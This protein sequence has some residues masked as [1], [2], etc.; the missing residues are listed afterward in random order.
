MNPLLLRYVLPAV[1]GLLLLLGIYLWGRSDGSNS[2]QA[3]WDRE[4]L[5]NARAVQQATEKARQTEAQSNAAIESNRRRS[6]AQIADI[7]RRRDAALQRLRD[8]ATPGGF[9]LPADAPAQSSER[10]EE[11][12]A[13]RDGGTS[14]ELLRYAAD[15]AI[16]QSAFDA[17]VRQ[18]E[19]IKESFR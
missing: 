17:C 2:V 1:A 12:L 3:Q 18:Y 13:G 16:L 7:A 4:R 6:D 5:A 9:R 11:G 10:A 15:A 8:A 19:A 14:A